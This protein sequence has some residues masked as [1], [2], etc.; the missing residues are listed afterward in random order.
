MTDLQDKTTTNVNYLSGEQLS[1]EVFISLD[2]LKTTARGLTVQTQKIN[3]YVT[4]K[5]FLEQCVR[6]F[7]R[8][9]ISI[10][11]ILP[12][13]DYNLNGFISHNLQPR[14]LDNPSFICL[15]TKVCWMPRF[16]GFF[17]S[18]VPSIIE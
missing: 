14:T 8:L 18:R 17:W 13:C 10:V 15:Q 3:R 4:K 9:I 7:T 11:T 5:N 2:G 12:K 16:T 1:K 6:K